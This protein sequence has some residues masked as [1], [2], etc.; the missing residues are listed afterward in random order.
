LVGEVFAAEPYE[1]SREKIREFAAAL[2]DDNPAYHDPDA[3]RRS[4]IGRDSSRPAS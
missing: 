1:V 4:A 3:R 2:R